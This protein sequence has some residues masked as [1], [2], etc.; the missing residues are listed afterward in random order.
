[1]QIKW[2]YSNVHSDALYSYLACQMWILHDNLFFLQVFPQRTNTNERKCIS[3]VLRHCQ[4]WALPIE[5]CNGCTAYHHNM[6]L[7]YGPN[8]LHRA[9]IGRWYSSITIIDV[10]K[11][12]HNVV[13]KGPA[14][15]TYIYTCRIY[16]MK[17]RNAKT[18]VWHGFR[19]CCRPP[20]SELGDSNAIFM[21]SDVV[22]W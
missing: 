1:M 15:S 10:L 7:A 20:I 22:E 18:F 2:K 12:G 17:A 5:Q 11:I 3:A 13:S 6:G 16:S 4:H 14:L 19:Q 9:H 8:T 21:G